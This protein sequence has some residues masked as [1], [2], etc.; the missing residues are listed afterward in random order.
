[1]FKWICWLPFKNIMHTWLPQA[2]SQMGTIPTS[3]H[4]A[5]KSRIFFSFFLKISTKVC[6]C[7]RSCRSLIVL[8]IQCCSH[9]YC[10]GSLT[11]KLS[12]SNLMASPCSPVMP[13]VTWCAKVYNIVLFLLWGLNAV[14][15]LK[16][17]CES[18]GVLIFFLSTEQELS[19]RLTQICAQAAF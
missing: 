3:G 14:V 10:L 17:H 18:E 1:M 5:R 8:I 13:P 11:I 16:R 4:D 12:L 9:F 19:H 2:S 7:I 15:L 6:S